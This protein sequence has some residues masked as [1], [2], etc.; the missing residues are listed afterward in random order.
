[1]LITD[2][3]SVLVFDPR[4]IVDLIGSIMG[5]CVHHFVNP[6][7]TR[8]SS[9]LHSGSGFAGKFYRDR[10]PDDRLNAATSCSY[11]WRVRPSH[12]RASSLVGK[13]RY[14]P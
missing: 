13:K 10:H 4:G 2:A 14:L 9:A 6:G 3:N 7:D 1:M 5:E 8:L 11:A 12:L